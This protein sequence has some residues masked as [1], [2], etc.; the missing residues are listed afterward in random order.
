ML[1]VDLDARWHVRVEW[2][3]MRISAAMLLAVLGPRWGDA[4]DV[5]ALIVLPVLVLAG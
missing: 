5:A 2:A 3:L 4:A 1:P